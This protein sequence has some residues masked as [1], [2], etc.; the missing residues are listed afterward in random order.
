MYVIIETQETNGVMAATEP[1]VKETKELADQEYHMKL[2]YAAVSNVDY[3]SVVMLNAQGQRVKGECMK[4]N[5][6][7]ENG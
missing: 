5:Q 2:S 1:V 7:E 4:H 6:D 3:H